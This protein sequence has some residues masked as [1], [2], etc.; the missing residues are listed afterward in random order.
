MHLDHDVVHVDH[1]GVR[2]IAKGILGGYRMA[3]GRGGGGGDM[4]HRGV[5]TFWYI[6]WGGYE[7]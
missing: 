7:G 4:A 3:Y 1:I 5:G 6:D 2:V